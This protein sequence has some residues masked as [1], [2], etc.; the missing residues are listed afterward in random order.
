MFTD[1]MF[2]LSFNVLHH[3]SPYVITSVTQ[4]T[5]NSITQVL[6]EQW[7]SQQFATR[8]A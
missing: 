8:G 1:R 3:I 4:R 2:W 5:N 6:T 7:H